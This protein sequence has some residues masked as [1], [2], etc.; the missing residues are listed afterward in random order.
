[1]YTVL[2]TCDVRKIGIERRSYLDEVST[3]SGSDR[4]CTRAYK[5]DYAV[6]CLAEIRH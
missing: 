1:M 5:E 2:F 4:V 3:G 6:F